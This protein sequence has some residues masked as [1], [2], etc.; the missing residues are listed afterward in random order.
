MGRVRAR[1]SQLA[2][3]FGSRRE[4]QTESSAAEAQLCSTLRVG[5]TALGRDDP[6]PAP[7]AADRPCSRGRRSVG[8]RSAP[9]QRHHGNQAAKVAREG[10]ALGRSG[11]GGPSQR[12][13]GAPLRGLRRGSACQVA[14]GAGAQVAEKWHQVQ[15]E[16]RC[17]RPRGAP[18]GASPAAGRESRRGSVPRGRGRSRPSGVGGGQCPRLGGSPPGCV[19]S[20]ASRRGPFGG[21]GTQLEPGTAPGWRDDQASR[22]GVGCHDCGMW[23]HPAGRRILEAC[24][25]RGP[26]FGC[27][28]VQTQVSIGLVSQRGR[29]SRWAVNPCR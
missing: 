10:S 1:V 16:A 2:G 28:A 15:T 22:P 29:T 13:V 19:P 12:G 6:G 20:R 24:A 9:G 18:S 26:L 3:C 8:W 25:R 21:R 27:C 7:P 17:Q 5:R 11:A 14:T 23:L 4:R